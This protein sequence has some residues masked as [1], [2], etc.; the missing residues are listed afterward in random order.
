[1][2]LK[3]TSRQR[4]LS[5]STGSK[6]KSQRARIADLVHQ[7]FGQCLP[8]DK[9]ARAVDL[10]NREAAVRLDLGDWI[11]DVLP[12]AGLVPIG[13]QAASRLGTALDNVSGEAALRLNYA[14]LDD[15]TI[16]IEESLVSDLGGVPIDWK[17]E[18]DRL[19]L[20][21]SADNTATFTRAK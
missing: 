3:P 19:T 10:R 1:M 15:D 4:Q 12:S 5:A 18:G 9:P 2:A 16:E 21:L 6:K 7:L 11:A 14:F 20:S 17:V 13:E 8:A